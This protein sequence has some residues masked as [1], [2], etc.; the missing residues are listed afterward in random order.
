MW[1]KIFYK[2]W[3]KCKELLVFPNTKPHQ[4]RQQQQYWPFLTKVHLVPVEGV[5]RVLPATKL[6]LGRQLRD[7]LLYRYEINIGEGETHHYDPLSLTMSVMWYAAC[8]NNPSRVYAKESFMV[9]HIQSIGN[10]KWALMH[11]IKCKC[12]WWI[13][14]FIERTINTR[15]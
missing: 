13:L 3:N 10:H 15:I 8:A 6:A 12:L 11:N 1:E 7:G 5:A 2:W 4:E 14:E 9:R